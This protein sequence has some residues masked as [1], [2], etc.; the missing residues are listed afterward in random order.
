MP[1][2]ES[3]NYLDMKYIGAIHCWLEDHT[4]H[5]EVKQNL[6]KFTQLIS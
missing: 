4:I 5:E 6:N 1:F 2:V 3:A